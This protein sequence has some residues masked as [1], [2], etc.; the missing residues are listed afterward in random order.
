MYDQLVAPTARRQR[1]EQERAKLYALPPP[2][3]GWNARDALPNMAETDAIV[4]DNW[5]PG[6][7]GI[8]LR[9]GSKVWAEGLGAPVETIFHYS[10]PMAI[11][12]RMF[13][14]TDGSIFDVTAGSATPVVTGTQNGRWSFVNFASAAAH[15]VYICNGFDAPRY[16]DG[17]AWTNSAFTGP[18]LLSS[19]EFVHSHMNRLWF[20]ERNTLNLWFSNVASIGGPLTKFSLSSLFRHG[21]RIV[22]LG[23]WSRDGGAGPDDNLVIVTSKGQVAIY[24][25][26]SPVSATTSALIGVYK[27]AEPIGGR[28][29]MNIGSDLAIITSNGFVPMSKVLPVG[30][31]AGSQAALTDKIGG[32]FMAAYRQGGRAFGWQAIE[33]PKAHLIIVNVPILERKQQEQFVINT[34]TGAWARWKDIQAGCWGL[35]GSDMYFGGNDGRVYLYGVGFQDEQNDDGVGKPITA[36]LAHAYSVMGTR[37]NKGFRMAR[38]RFSSPPAFAPLVQMRVNYDVTRPTLTIVNAGQSGSTWAAEPGY[39]VS[40][41]GTSFTPGI[42]NVGGRYQWY[43]QGDPDLVPPR[44]AAVVTPITAL[45]EGGMVPALPWQSIERVGLAGAIIFGLS[46]STELI[47]NGCDVT[48]EVG[49]ML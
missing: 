10:P 12:N 43:D 36:N 22:A 45:W 5:V 15:V 6:V 3:G 40:P 23:S 24:A 20:V 33:Y 28:C 1:R 2:I 11:S 8:V 26:T 32:A 19:L 42:V 46:S 7:N 27:I 44:Q 31:T 4:L 13:A 18:T 47:Y 34:H 9:N 49:G 35:F 37:R 41:D 17:T 14:A 48:F 21:G 38:P 16:W 39:A 25:G 29:V 30:E